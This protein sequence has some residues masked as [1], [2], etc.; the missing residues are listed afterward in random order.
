MIVEI[1]ARARAELASAV[2]YLKGENP[3]AAEKIG[4]AIERAIDTLADMPGRGRSGRVAGTRELVVRGAPYILVY[5][6]ADAAVFVL[7]IRH[8][9]RGW[10]R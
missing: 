8:K 7:S 10:G 6:V 2:A 5:T 3:Q 1:S 9:S 4:A